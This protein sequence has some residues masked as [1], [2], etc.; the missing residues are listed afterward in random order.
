MTDTE[1]GLRLPHVIIRKDSGMTDSLRERVARAINQFD[2]PYLNADAA[3]D[4]ILEEA[5]KVVDQ[6]AERTQPW[7]GAS[8]EDIERIATAIRAL[9]KENG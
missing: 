1:G 8:V 5:A 2:S 6:T 3:I 9:G 7:S 4:I